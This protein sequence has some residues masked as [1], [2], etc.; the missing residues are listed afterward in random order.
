MTKRQ[1][2]SIPK[3]MAMFAICFGFFVSAAPTAEAQCPTPDGLD[4]T[5]CCTPA[6]PNLPAFPAFTM[7]SAG[8]CWQACMPLPKQCVIQDVGAPVPTTGCTQ[9]NAPLSVLDCASGATLMKGDLVLDYT[10]TWT[11]TPIPGGPPAQVWRF[12]AKVDMEGSG[13]TSAACPVPSCANVAGST[14]FYYGYVDYSLDCVSGVWSQ[15]VVLYHNCDRFVHN[16]SL[17]AVPGPFHPDRTYALVGPDTAA[18]PFT[19]AIFLPAPATTIGEAMR[20]ASPAAGVC[21]AEEPLLQGQFIPQLTG[22]ACPLSP[23]PPQS[24]GNRFDGSGACGSSFMSLNIFPTAPWYHLVTTSLGFWS[25][26]ASYPGPER[27]SVAEGL[28]LYR[29]ACEP[30]PF[31]QTFDVFYGGMTE[32]GYTSDPT[33]PLA[34]PSSRF[35]DLASNYTLPVGAPFAFPAVGVVMPTRHLIYVNL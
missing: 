35:L 10:R 27:A 29:D 17:S 9:Y 8:I 18:N 11:E 4:A 31:N 21:L 26:S 14:A 1:L 12:A 13:A 23:Q 16:P 28:L 7:P 3:W 30:P 20:N 34:P 22:C 2:L 33:L 5:S 19:P 32:G 6:T 15:A 25:T 24:S